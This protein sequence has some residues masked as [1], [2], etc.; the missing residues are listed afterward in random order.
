MKINKHPHH[1]NNSGFTLAEI[2][3]VLL[4]IIVVA[5]GAVIGFQRAIRA[6]NITS[7]AT[8]VN[9]AHTAITLYKRGPGTR[10]LPDTVDAT[11]ASQITGT[12][13]GVTPIQPYLDLQTVLISARCLK[14][15]ITVSLGDQGT[16]SGTVPVLWDQTALAWYT[17]HDNAPTRSYLDSSGNLIRARLLSATV[18]ATAPS[19]ANGTNF[20]LQ[21][22]TDLTPGNTVYFWAI[23]GVTPDERQ[24]LVKTLY[25]GGVAAASG[26]AQDDGPVA[27]PAATGKTTVYVYV[28]D[29]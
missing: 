9:T 24:D 14:S 26:A 4:I 20:R 16:P 3:V 10:S 5:T 28:Y 17:P 22:G 18:T 25:A 12:L 21:S 6:S 27:F 11:P 1:R 2:L 23:P 8:A 29:E 7:V 19:T 15:A 13:G